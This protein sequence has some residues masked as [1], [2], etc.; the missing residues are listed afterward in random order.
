[1]RTVKLNKLSI[2][3][4]LFLILFPNPLHAEMKVFQTKEVAI[5]FDKRLE[6]VAREVQSLYPSVKTD[7]VGTLKWDVDFVP[8]VVLIKDKEAFSKVGGGDLVIAFA[9]PARNLIVLDTSRVY[10]KPFTLESTLKH[11]LC[12]L[13]LHKNI[14]DERLP[15]WLDEGVCQWASGGIAELMME[16]G[17]KTLTR[18]TIS[19]KVISL[20][21]LD[22]FPRDGKSLIL[23]YEESKSI[24]EYIANEYG[25]KGILQVLE[26][27]K[28]GNS[29][30]DSIRKSLSISSSELETKWLAHLKRKHTWLSYLSYNIYTIIFFLAAIITVYGFIRLLKKK[31]E[32]V[33]EDEEE[34]KGG[35]TA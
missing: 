8:D 13:V 16:D 35:G 12:H 18:A 34:G 20:E 14:D 5:L 33:D 6:N 23:A 30:N 31:R 7:I 32:Y 27:L 26:Y 11:E 19:G 21:N 29:V 2:F 17:E 15:R 24:V 22:T 28:E 9:V 10:T 25:D 1:M 4:F 3:F